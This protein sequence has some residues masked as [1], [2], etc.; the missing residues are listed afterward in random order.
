MTSP[1]N[2]G[3]DGY[4][5]SRHDLD[6]ALELR[7]RTVSLPKIPSVQVMRHFGTR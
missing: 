7:I 2:P 1:E 6:Q 4:P 3:R 5:R